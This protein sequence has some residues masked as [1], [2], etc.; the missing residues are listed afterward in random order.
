[1]HFDTRS[2]FL[3]VLSGTKKVLLLPPSNKKDIYLENF[4]IINTI[5]KDTI[6]KNI[7][8]KSDDNIYD[9]YYILYTNFVDFLFYFKFE[10][11]ICILM[12]ILINNFKIKLS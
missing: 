10:T 5:K 8:I 4:S 11:I 1:M 9:K 7:I 3:Y 2:K 6:N 12:I